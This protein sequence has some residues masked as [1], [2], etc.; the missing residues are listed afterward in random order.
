MTR[1]MTFASMALLTAMAARAADD[2]SGLGAP[3][4]PAAN[5]GLTEFE[6]PNLDGKQTY[7]VGLI[8]SNVRLDFLKTAV[9]NHIA[10]RLNGV[11]TR[12]QKNPLVAAWTAYEEANKADALQTVVPQPTTAKPADPDYKAAY[13]A[14]I[15]DLTAGNVRRAGSGEPK[16]RAVKDPLISTVT[17]VVIREVFAG[18]KATDA[19]YTFLQAKAE[20][21]PD[22]IAYLN[23]LIEAKVAAGADR[24][25]LEKM[26]DTKYIGPAKAM[27]GLHTT[28]AQS[29]LPS[30]L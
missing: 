13:D 6:F 18:R 9:R 24:A 30:I 27:L 29:E 12:H 23:K 25:A 19:K 5:P 10:N 11:H 7:D 15:A 16:P 20:V 3:V 21:G 28:K 17:D 8:P 22:G 2:A 14:A 4:A 26:R 1:I